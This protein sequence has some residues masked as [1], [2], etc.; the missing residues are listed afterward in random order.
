MVLDREGEGGEFAETGARGCPSAEETRETGSFGMKTRWMMVLAACAW[1]MAAAGAVA[2]DQAPDQAP[3]EAAAETLGL[4][5]GALADGDYSKALFFVDMTS[6]R[7][8]LLSRRMGELKARNPGLT[9]KDLEEMSATIQTREL[10][11]GNLRGILGAMWKQARYE[12]MTWEAKEW[13]RLPGEEEEWLARVEGK[14]PDGSEVVFAAGLRK[15]GDEW[16]VAPDIVERLTAA[17]PLRAPQE[18]PMPDEVAAAVEAYWGAWKAGEL[19]EAWKMMSEGA[20]AKQPLAGFLEQA[21]A[22]VAATGTP[23]AWTQEHCRELAPGLLGLGFLLTAKE[24]FRSVMVF[25]KGEDGAWALEDIQF[26]RASAPET[27]PV[28]VPAG[29]GGADATGGSLA[30]DLKVKGL[31]SDFKTSL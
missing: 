12:G 4:Y 31:T 15:S 3:D 1:G 21:G 2:A 9:S 10:A 8:Y 22:L 26:R 11:P 5:A 6:L 16:L 27:R 7:Q 29:A 20:R 30:P 14:R 13:K 28:V 23:V 18:V 24:P 17:L 19:E 25:R